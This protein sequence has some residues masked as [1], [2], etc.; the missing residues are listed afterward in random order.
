MKRAA[1]L[2]NQ[3]AVS[4]GGGGV[5]VGEIATTTGTFVY[6]ET[7]NSEQ[8][9]VELTIAGQLA[10]GSIW[11]DFVNVT[12]QTTIRAYHKIDGTNYRQFQENVWAVADDDGVLIEGF[13]AYSDVKIS[14]QCGGGGAGSVNVPYAVV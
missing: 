9:V 11:L 1:S 2:V 5:I 7:D 6:D 14:L 12:Q 8:E 3:A 10:I 4:G 13:V